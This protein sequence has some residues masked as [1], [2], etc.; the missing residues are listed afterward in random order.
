[1]SAQLFDPAQGPTGGWPPAARLE[2]AYLEGFATQG[3]QGLIANLRT[4][5]SGARHG[6]RILPTTVNAAEY[7]DKLIVE[8]TPPADGPDW[9]LILQGK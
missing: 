7:G 2:R 1:M 5:V 3:S 8:F 9:T 6:E 4:R